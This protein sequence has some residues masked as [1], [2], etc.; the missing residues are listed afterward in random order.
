MSADLLRAAA[1]VLRERAEA[2]A[3]VVEITNGKDTTTAY[4]RGGDYFLDLAGGHPQATR[5]GVTVTREF[6][7]WMHPDLGLALAD[8]LDLTARRFDEGLGLPGDYE[9]PLAVALI[10]GGAPS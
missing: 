4:R 2:G 5:S 6:H 1:Q 9:K 7:E 3:D 10:V 8:W